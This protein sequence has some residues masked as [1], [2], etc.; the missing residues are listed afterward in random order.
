MKHKPKPVVHHKKPVVHKK[1]K[2]VHKHA[3]K[4]TVH[5]VTHK[6]T[7][8]ASI[9]ASAKAHTSTHLVDLALEGVHVNLRRSS[10]AKKHDG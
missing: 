7:K 8:V 2:I 9:S 5:V 6:V 1:I 4:P 3:T 10:S